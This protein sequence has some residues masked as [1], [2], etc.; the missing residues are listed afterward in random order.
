MS[1]DLNTVLLAGY[2]PMGAVVGA[3]WAAL[4]KE[5][6]EHIATLRRSKGMHD[7][8][9]SDLENRLAELEDAD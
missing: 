3:L 1:I 8:T 6:K 7:N 5:R 2:A 9:I 4:Q